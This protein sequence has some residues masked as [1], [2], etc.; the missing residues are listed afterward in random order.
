MARW[1]TR[2]LPPIA[3]LLSLAAGSAEA[4][5]HAEMTPDTSATVRAAQ[6]AAQAW[7]GHVDAGA[8]DA[9]WDEMAP[10]L[11]DTVSQ[12]QWRTRRTEARAALGAARSRQ[13]VRA[14]ARDSLGR[15]PNAGPF[16]LLRY[17]STFGP[18]LYVEAVL[19]EDTGDAWRVAGYEVGPVAGR[20]ERHP[21]PS[22]A[23]APAT[24]DGP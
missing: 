5:G 10:G 4:Q 13:L 17:H 9:A 22:D 6:T 16:V 19:V 18:D 1:A 11:R 12:E 8:W 15:A 24:D 23:D 3:I 2:L 7:L 21:R 20:P 14:V